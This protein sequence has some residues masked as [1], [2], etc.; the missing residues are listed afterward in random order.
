MLLR[1]FHFLLFVSIGLYLTG[2]NISIRGTVTDRTTGTPIEFVTVFIDGTN[3]NTE[4]DEEG[5]YQITVERQRSVTVVF[6]RLGYDEGKMNI[7]AN[8]DRFDV[9]ITLLS[10]VS[11]MMT[12]AASSLAHAL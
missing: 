5:K 2:Q 7:R 6:S 9:D 3:I 11:E 10:S 4:T 1:L 12:Q 8:R